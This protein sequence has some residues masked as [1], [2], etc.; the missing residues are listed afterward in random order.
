MSDARRYAE[1]L[2]RLRFPDHLCN[3][4]TFLDDAQRVIQQAIEAE[5]EACA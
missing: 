4:C 3:D 2:H 1:E 5:R